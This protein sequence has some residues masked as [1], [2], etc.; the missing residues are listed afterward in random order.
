MH[1]FILFLL[2]KLS[3][4]N[5]YLESESCTFRICIL[6]TPRNLNT[7]RMKMKYY[8]YP[9]FKNLQIGAKNTQYHIP[10]FI[11]AFLLSI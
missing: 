2:I 1:I 11:Q 6:F 3:V 10:Y 4:R 5:K 8:L 7:L 9:N